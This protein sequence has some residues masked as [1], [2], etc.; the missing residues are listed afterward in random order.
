MNGSTGGRIL[1]DAPAVACAS[2]S[3]RVERTFAYASA[4]PPTCASPL[5]GQGPLSHDMYVM[6]ITYR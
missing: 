2:A 6:W 3:T 1:V 4:H 5:V